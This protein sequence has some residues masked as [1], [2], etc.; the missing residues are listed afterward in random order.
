MDLIQKAGIA[1][2]H[3]KSNGGNGYRFFAQEMNARALAEMA[4][5]NDLRHALERDEMVLHYQTQVDTFS[6]E[7]VGVEALLRWQHH[8]LGLLMPKDFIGLAEENGLIVPIGDWVLHEACR[9]TKLWHDAGH[10]RLFVSVNVS[11]LQFKQG[12]LAQTAMKAIGASGLEPRFVELELTESMIMS[13]FE[14]TQATLKTLK[15]FGVRFSIDDF[16]T[17]YS[18]LNYLKHFPIDKLQIDISF[19]TDVATAPDNAAIVKAIIAMG[20]NLELK[21]IA[22][23]VETEAQAGYLR[24]LHCDDMQGY[25]F[26]RPAPAQEIVA[27]LGAHQPL[28]TGAEDERVLLLVDDEANVISA[29]KR[30]L[31]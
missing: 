17:G 16:G 7:I 2:R 23:G 24:T 13:H 9:Q 26:S 27:L 4:L 12:N 5:S 11:A 18:S 29:L 14:Q 20:H 21:V 31:R 6:G 3:V 25:Y 8:D 30:V 1:M 19:I 22:E 10:S 28:R 15:G